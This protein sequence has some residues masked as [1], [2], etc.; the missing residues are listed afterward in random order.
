LYAGSLQQPPLLQPPVVQ[1]S[2]TS[3][4]IDK[5]SGVHVEATV[6]WKLIIKGPLEDVPHPAV[7]VFTNRHPGPKLKPPGYMFCKSHNQLP[8]EPKGLPGANIGVKFVHPTP[9]LI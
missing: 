9:K 8:T 6:T 2:K 4:E 1:S 7:P 5:L 3:I